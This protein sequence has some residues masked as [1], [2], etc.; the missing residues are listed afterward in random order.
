MQAEAPTYT[1]KEIHADDQLE[2]DYFR[3]WLVCCHFGGQATVE[4]DY[5]CDG[6][7]DGKVL[8]E[9]DLAGLSILHV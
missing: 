5:A 1:L 3:Q 2:A 9:K 6:D 7:T 8:D 4:Q